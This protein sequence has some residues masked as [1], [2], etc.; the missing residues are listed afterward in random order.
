MDSGQEILRKHFKQVKLVADPEELLEEVSDAHAIVTRLKAI[1]HELIESAS[2]LKIIVRHGVG[3]DKIDIASAT[4][5]G[6]LVA[7][8]P[9][10]LSTSVAEYTVGTII[11][12]LRLIREA[13]R[14]VRSG[15][16]N[17]R[18]HELIGTELSGK[19]IG[20]VGL[21]RIGSEVAKRLNSFETNLI[22]YDLVRQ[23]QREK[24]LT[25]KYSSL[26]SLLK[27]S[28][29]VCLH[30]PATADTMHMIGENE[31]ASMRPAALLINM[32]RGSVIEEKALVDA[33]STNR[34][35]GAALDVFDPE[36]PL[37]TNPL[38]QLSNVLLSPHMSGHTKEALS[39]TS[40]EVADAVIAGL[41]GKRPRHLSN[42]EVL[43]RPTK[44]QRKTNSSCDCTL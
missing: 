17:A 1:D 8:T 22:Y 15:N 20:I 10:S 29:I 36:P 11:S 34:L 27:R 26:N 7:Y 35:R 21:G 2:L 32:S 24:K 6:V 43:T 25:I 38:L 42:P 14:S 4:E 33:L 19:T 39:R 18:Q 37:L 13:D 41:S 9:E 5:H 3:T 28:D 23:P 40:V 44:P 16:W 31:L 30:V 12:L